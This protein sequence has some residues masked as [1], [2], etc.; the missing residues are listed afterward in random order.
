MHASK[1]IKMS[2]KSQKEEEIIVDIEE[3]YSKSEQFIEKYK[4]PILYVLGALVVIVGGIFAYQKLHLEP[5]EAE[6]K[7]MMFV[8]EQHFAND[9][10]NLAINGDAENN[11]GFFGYHRYIQWNQIC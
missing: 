8:A 11:Y 1:A 3:V 6:A 2:K 9:S 5:L 4:Q 7:S 10:L